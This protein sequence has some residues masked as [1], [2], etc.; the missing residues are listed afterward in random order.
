MEPLVTVA[1]AAYNVEKF[2]ISGVKYIIN[3]TY[4]NLDIIIVDDGSTDNTSHLCDELKEKDNRIRVFHKE[5]GG[6]G[7]ARNVGIDNSKGEFIYF[8]DVDDS[9]EVDFIENAVK[10]ATENAADLVIFG[11]YVKV[12]SEPGEEKISL[13]EHIIHSNND[14]KKVYSDELLWM[15]HGNGFAWNK[16]YRMSFLKKCNFHFGNQRI[17]EDEIFNMQLYPRLN[18]V[19]VSSE[20]YY[21]YVIY[22][23][24]NACSRY[25]PNKSE[26]ILD[27]YYKFTDLYNNWQINDDRVLDYIQLRFL[28][29]MYN[30]VCQ[31][32]FHKD[33]NYAKSELKKEVNKVFNNKELIEVLLKNKIQYVKNPINNIQ[34]WA[35]NH[36]KTNLIIMITKLKNQIKNS[37]I[38]MRLYKSFKF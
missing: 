22:L 31:N 25:L 20:V 34:I 38:I 10:M 8:F 35:F 29:G 3:Q 6:P 27:V 9:I 26:F 36:R 17:Q 18:D 1:I 16:F 5:N 33:C 2:L 32:Y 24:G 37:E 28:K 21:H 7:S 4:K 13:N 14:L 23:N 11:Y 12:N 30:V 15:K 19:Y